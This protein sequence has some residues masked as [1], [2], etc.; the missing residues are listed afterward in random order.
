MSI[1]IHTPDPKMQ[2]VYQFFHNYYQPISYFFYA[3]LVI[4]I[5]FL[6]LFSLYARFKFKFWRE[7][8]VFHIYDLHYY[9]FAPGIIRDTLPEKN[10]YCN[11][12]DIETRPFTDVS[13]LKIKLFVQFIKQHYLQNKE[14]VFDPRED[15]ILP[16]MKGHNA[17]CFLSL[18][19]QEELLMDTKTNTS[20][21]DR[22]IIASMTSRPVNLSIPG[23]SQIQAYYVDYLCVDKWKRKQGIAEQMIQTHHYTQSHSNKNMVVSLFKREGVLTGIVPLC[24]YTTSCFPMK[25][26]RKP[27]NILDVFSLLEVNQSNIGYLIEFMKSA[28]EK[29]TF[30]IMILSEY[31]NLLEL[32]N[33]ENVFVYILLNKATNQMEAVYFFRKTCTFIEKKAEVLTCF[34][35]IV[36]GECDKN[37]FVHAFKVAL[38]KIKEKNPGF[39]YLAVEKISHNDILVDNLKKKTIPCIEMPCAYFFY[40]F[41]Y[42]TFNP[43]KVLI[44]C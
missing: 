31:S 10:K 8:P 27:A 37:I 20:I 32:C 41:A 33:T 1:K 7:Q 43:Q 13:P 19:Y 39:Q 9:L 25:G 29:K 44:I 17:P 6:T 18:Y 23:F 22:K 24:V 14:N 15:H 40:N 28:L 12:K 16:Y 11:F 4:S 36:S 5:L 38:W 42:P 2:Q 35:S 3:I 34:A 30:D 26:W 21:M